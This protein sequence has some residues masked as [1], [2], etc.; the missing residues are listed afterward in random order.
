MPGSAEVV[1]EASGDALKE[2]WNG[3]SKSL[4]ESLYTS[5]PRRIA[6]DIKAEGWYTKY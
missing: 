4:L 2:I 3:I 5:M 1:K 6:A